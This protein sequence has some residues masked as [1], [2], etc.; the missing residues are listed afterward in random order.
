MAIGFA[1]EFSRAL[2]AAEAPGSGWSCSSASVRMFK[3]LPE[4]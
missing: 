4:P 1:A 2:A 3:S